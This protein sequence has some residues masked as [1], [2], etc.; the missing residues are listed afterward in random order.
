MRSFF[1]QILSVSSRNTRLHDFDAPNDGDLSNSK[2]RAAIVSSIKALARGFYRILL[3]LRSF[4][5]EKVVYRLHFLNSDYFSMLVE[6]VR[7]LYDG[8]PKQ[9][10]RSVTLASRFLEGHG[11][12]PAHIKHLLYQEDIE[13]LYTTAALRGASQPGVFHNDCK[14]D[15]GCIAASIHKP[16]HVEH[17]CTCTVVRPDM[18]RVNSIIEEDNIPVIE[19]R[20]TEGLRLSLKVK[21]AEAQTDYTAISHVWT[22][23]IA[24]PSTNGLLACQLSK[25]AQDVQLI[26][27]ERPLFPG[28][29]PTDH[30]RPEFA[31]AIRRESDGPVTIWMDALCIPCDDRKGGETPSALKTRAIALMSSTYAGAS[32]VLV[33]DK[34]IEVMDYTKYSGAEKKYSLLQRVRFTPWM[35]RS[36]TL[37]EG[38]LAK[39]L[40][41]R[42]TKFPEHI[43]HLRLP[44][45]PRVWERRFVTSINRLSRRD[46]SEKKDVYQ[47]LANLCLFDFSELESVPEELR[48]QALLRTQSPEFPFGLLQRKNDSEKS[49]LHEDWWI[50]TCKDRV[51]LPV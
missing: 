9:S 15:V 51:H 33:I 25:I 17:G 35:W 8:L 16:H 18:Y 37:Q 22:D 5:C 46:T 4:H 49:S 30:K 39:F 14:E 26:K 10:P 29:F 50:P 23:G 28:R 32:E 47:I 27:K 36:W 42:T 7:L 19:I 20:R 13:T 48:F 31:E 38:A 34:T 24:D 40:Y 45:K 3:Q 2:L 11:W 1:S 41:V 6:T 43:D 44:L 21:S 12:C